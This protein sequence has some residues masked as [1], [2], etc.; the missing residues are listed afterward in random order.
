[1]SDH[2]IKLPNTET[3]CASTLFPLKIAGSSL[4]HAFLMLRKGSV[5]L[6][7][8]T[9]LNGAIWSHNI[10]ANNNT[11]SL[12]VPSKFMETM[13]DSWNWNNKNFAGLGR[14][15]SRAIRG[16]GYDTFQRF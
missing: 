8:N 5:E 11:L 13:Y 2:D 1:V 14:S 10:C 15:I 12:N 16:S 9:S 4:P 3:T 6:T 7:A